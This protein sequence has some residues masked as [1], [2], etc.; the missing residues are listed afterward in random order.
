MFI[1][2]AFFA[3]FDSRYV[4]FYVNLFVLKF[5]TSYDLF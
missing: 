1:A 4:T 3:F 2:S 5:E